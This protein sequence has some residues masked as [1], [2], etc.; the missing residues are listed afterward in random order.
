MYST[1]FKFQL[2][3]KDDFLKKL[4]DPWISIEKVI[5]VAKIC[6]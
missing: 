1:S 4:L 3:E 6:N 5:F 2:Q